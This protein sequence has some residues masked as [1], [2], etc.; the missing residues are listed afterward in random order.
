MAAI[1]SWH[2]GLCRRAGKGE[3]KTLEVG[4]GRECSTLT[5]TPK[6][7][8]VLEWLQNAAP[9]IPITP[10]DGSA[11]LLVLHTAPAVLALQEERGPQGMSP[12]SSSWGR[13]EAQGNTAL[14]GIILQGSGFAVPQQHTAL[15]PSLTAPGGHP[16]ELPS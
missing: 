15:S 4:L 2:L 9:S 5:N 7:Y 3:N 11:E 12:S 14:K 16:R 10:K 6:P 1:C 13:T 8:G